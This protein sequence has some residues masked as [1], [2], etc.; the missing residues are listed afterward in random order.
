[1]PNETYHE[2]LPDISALQTLDWFV[3]FD[4]LI[5]CFCADFDTNALKIM[6][7]YFPLHKNDWASASQE[8]LLLT[9][10]PEMLILPLW[11]EAKES[12]FLQTHPGDL[13]A[14]PVC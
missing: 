2:E 11:S 10:T 9:S 13:D 7:L 4:Q 8:C 5:D 6:F 12:E 1:M 3:W 14:E